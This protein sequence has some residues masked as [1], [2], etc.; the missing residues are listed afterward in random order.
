MK[1]IESLAKHVNDTADAITKGEKGM[2][3]VNFTER[4]ISKNE[5]VQRVVYTYAESDCVETSYIQ[6]RGSWVEVDADNI[7][8]L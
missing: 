1:A 8:W 3:L 4:G 2:C 5:F 6:W 7:A